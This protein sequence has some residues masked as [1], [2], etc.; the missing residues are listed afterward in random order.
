MKEPSDPAGLREQV[1]VLFDQWG[2][3]SEEQPANQMHDKFVLKLQT[4]GF[5]KVAP[6]TYTSCCLSPLERHAETSWYGAWVDYGA[7]VRLSWNHDLICMC[8]IGCA[9]ASVSGVTL[10]TLSD[11]HLRPGRCVKSL[12]Q[13]LQHV[14]SRVDE[15]WC[16]YEHTGC[17]EVHVLNAA[18]SIIQHMGRTWAAV[19][20]T[21]VHVL[22]R[23]CATLQRL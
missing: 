18:F 5:L 3:L 15:E 2:R 17:A 6:T 9:H 20:Y 1:V 14:V 8:S 12:V 21:C 23:H 13:L 10:C 11:T 7:C 4:A 22:N 19:Q 16:G